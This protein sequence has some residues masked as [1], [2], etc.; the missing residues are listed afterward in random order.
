MPCRA[1][2]S[3]V[4][5]LPLRV[6]NGAGRHCGFDELDGLE[7]LRALE[8][9]LLAQITEMQ[10]PRQLLQ[11]NIVSQKGAGEGEVTVISTVPHDNVER[12]RIQQVVGTK[13]LATRLSHRG[14]Q[15]DLAM[16]Q[17]QRQPM[18][19]RVFRRGEFKNLKAAAI[20]AIL[21]SVAVVAFFGAGPLAR[22]FDMLGAIK[23]AAVVVIWPTTTV[24][25]MRHYLRRSMK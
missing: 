23:P 13:K 15:I 8:Y 5:L 9:D 18:K 3:L 4:A 25:R 10:S 21:V 11:R 20:E 1:A 16:L 2:S 17:Q 7:C 6:V 12:L 19:R 22:Q 14:A 24:E